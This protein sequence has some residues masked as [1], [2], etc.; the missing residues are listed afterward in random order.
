MFNF[1]LLSLIF[2]F[3]LLHSLYFAFFHF[4]FFPICFF[5]ALFF[6]LAYFCLTSVSFIP[7][8]FLISSIFLPFS[9]V[10]FKFPLTFSL[11]SSISY[12]Y[13]SLSR[14][15]GFIAVFKKIQVLWVK[16]SCQ[17]VSYRRFGGALLPSYLPNPTGATLWTYFTPKMEVAITSAILVTVTSWHD[18]TLHDSNLVFFLL[19]PFSFFSC[20]AFFPF[21]TI[22]Y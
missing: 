11:P 6:F 22:L 7:S 17:L 10:A 15:E 5:L 18:D 3:C 12:Y 20:A 4:S 2:S 16:T 14:F 19:P 13:R 1:I 9:F 21:L 8:S